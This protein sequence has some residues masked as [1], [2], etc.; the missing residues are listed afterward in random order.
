MR[1][2]FLILPLALLATLPW[3]ASPQQAV[4]PQRLATREISLGKMDPGLL[5]ESLVVSPDCRH[6]GYIA[7]H[8]QTRCVMVDG[9]AGTAYEV[10]GGLIFSP[11]SRRTAYMARREGRSFVVVNGK[12]GKAYEAIL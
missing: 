7:A 5:K 11:D 8:D 9:V 4:S 10:V 2:A 3:P 12:E 6:V 1:N